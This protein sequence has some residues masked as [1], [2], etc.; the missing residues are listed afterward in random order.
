[1]DSRLPL[2][3]AQVRPDVSSPSPPAPRHLGA[4]S[5]PGREG[6]GEDLRGLGR[7]SASKTRCALRRMPGEH[8]QGLF[9]PPDSPL[10]VLPP[11]PTPVHR[12]RP[13][14]CC[15]FP[16]P[17]GSALIFPSSS[18]HFPLGPLEGASMPG[19]G[20][21]PAH[22]CTL[23]HTH[24]QAPC[25]H[26]SQASPALPP[27]LPPLTENMEVLG[28]GVSCSCGE[29]LLA[30]GSQ[31]RGRWSPPP[32]SSPGSFPFSS[33]P[34]TGP[35]EGGLRTS[36]VPGQ[37]PPSTPVGTGETGPPSPSGSPPVRPHTPIL[38]WPESC[39]P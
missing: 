29:T 21:T 30:A 39:C 14:L 8:A 23:K 33:S 6:P 36:S 35:G 7:G 24:T 2:L 12:L 28:L 38:G 11:V 9:S 1:M 31:A 3:Q 15:L 13:W 25:T 32:P 20:C 18:R 4:S 5:D 34:G 10:C 16:D 17:S 26:G 37:G 19:P 22:T 27:P